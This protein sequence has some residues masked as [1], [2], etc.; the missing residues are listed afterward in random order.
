MI[1]ALLFSV[2]LAA[3]FIY[4]V[5]EMK[6]SRLVGAAIVLVTIATLIAA[7]F[8]EPA[9]S[10][11][12]AI[13]LDGHRQLLLVLAMSMLLLIVLNLHLKNRRTMGM[14]TMLT[15]EIA[16]GGAHAADGSPRRAAHGPAPLHAPIE[17]ARAHQPVARVKPRRQRDRART[18]G[19]FQKEE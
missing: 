15:R 17:T 16:I 18:A 14:L 11:A 3:I 7:W 1:D 8:H 13:G 9:T 19:V 10:V 4:G 2:P 6:G 12:V 5:L